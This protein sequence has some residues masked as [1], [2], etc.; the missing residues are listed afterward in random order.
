MFQRICSG[1]NDFSFDFGSAEHKKK[2]WARCSQWRG[3]RAKGAHV[4]MG[5]WYDLFEK[6]LQRGPEEDAIELLVL[7]YVG[8]RGS[9]WP[10]SGSPR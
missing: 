5:R 9:W 3:L 1:I 2:V 4:R 10:P 7:L 8:M 6:D